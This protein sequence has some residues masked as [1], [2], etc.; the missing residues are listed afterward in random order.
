[1]FYNQSNG[2]RKLICSV[3]GG[4]VYGIGLWF[5]IDAGAYASKHPT[6]YLKYKFQ[7]FLPFIF[8]SLIGLTAVNC[9]SAEDFRGQGLSETQ[10]K[11][12][13]TCFLLGFVT[14]ILTLLGSF[15]IAIEQ[16][17]ATDTELGGY[18]GVGLVMAS[19]ATVLAAF[20]V[21]FGHW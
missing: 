1:M 8:G 17:W 11:R 13:R 10:T 16:Y 7:W 2:T 18:P 15:W 6:E 3:L 21:R 14:L 20:I 19:S 5:L 12:A 9:W 4:I